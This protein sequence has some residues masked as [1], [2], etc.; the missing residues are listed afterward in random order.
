M[1]TTTRTAG[2][3]ALLLLAFCGPLHAQTDGSAVFRVTTL[4]TPQ[5][6]AP[7][8][9]IAIWVT[10][11]NGAFVRTLKKQAGS[12]KQVNLVKWVAS[13]Q[14]NVVDAITGATLKTQEVHQITWNCRNAARALVGDGTYRIMVEM[15]SDDA[16][17]PVTPTNYIQFTKGPAGVTVAPA[18]LPYFTGISLTYTP[19]NGH[20]IAVS[21]IT[22]ASGVT[23]TTIPITITVTNRQ[24]STESFNIALSNTTSSLLIGS[25]AVTALAP[26]S[27]TNVTI[28]WNTTALTSGVYTLKA[29]AAAVAGETSLA[30]N[31]LASTV[32][33]V[34]A[35]VIPDLAVTAITPAAGLTGAT[36]PVIVTVTNRKLTTESFS[37]V[38][39]N[40]TSGVLIGSA[41]VSALGPFA[42]TTVTINWNTTS[43]P[44]GGYTLKAVAGPAAGETN[45]ANNTLTSGL[46]LTAP[47]PVL[48]G[49][50]TFRVTTM[51]TYLGLD[52]INVVAI[53]VT[54]GNGKFIRTLKKCATVREPFLLKWIASS[55]YNVV[56]AVTGATLTTQATHQV[57][58]N[59]RNAAGK[60]VTN[61]V[62]QI[63]VEMTT[64]DAQGP[65]T[66]INYLAFTK[67]KKAVTL[68]PANLPF[69]TGMA[70]TYTPVYARDIAVTAVRPSLGIIG[71]TIPV[72]ATL[73][74]LLATPETFTV[75]L[76]DHNTG[77]LLTSVSGIT[78]G[79]KA[80]RTVTLPWRT[81]G[82][83]GGNHIIDVVAGPVPG[84]TNI[85][86]NTR[87]ATL[88][89]AP[90][91]EVPVAGTATFR[92]TTQKTLKG[93]DPQNIMAIW[94][95]D[96]NGFFVKTLKKRAAVRQQYLI[97]WLASSR[98]D[99]TDAVTG[100]TLATH[101]AH[102]VTWNCR[103]SDGFVVPN[104]LYR[105]MVEM[106]TEDGQG[107]VTPAKY[108]QFNKGKTAVT[109]A[110]ANLPNF[111]AMS[112]TY[113][114]TPAPVAAVAKAV[115]AAS[116]PIVATAVRTPAPSVVKESAPG[117]SA[118]VVITNGM[119][120][121]SQGATL[122]LLADD[123]TGTYLPLGS[124]ALPG[125]I[126][127]MAA[128]GTYVITANG[129]HGVYI[130][131]TLNPMDPVLVG[132]YPTK[133]AAL[134]VTIDGA[135]VYV[136]D[137][138]AG[139]LAVDVSDPTVPIL[140]G[141][142][143]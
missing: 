33:L 134:A 75:A 3:T 71:V 12:S 22:P 63:R 4:K 58:W 35:A 85:A 69:F 37:V 87:S 120:A 83:A 26:F 90:P 141:V 52:P 64:Q 38:L 91:A 54:D 73:T 115:P 80:G 74:N 15:T 119:L 118:V 113:T 106:T 104:G 142:V 24:S 132:S 130:V 29:T 16:V 93:F 123:G 102:V 23:G 112:L 50:L 20:D 44:A 31:T 100:A 117:Y 89:L 2:L 45:L 10:D 125:A 114:P 76:K 60:L 95:T 66:P 103:N 11:G 32:T 21:R 140:L 99:I 9:I 42:G 49:S 55:K 36:I 92:V 8:N 7:K 70:L 14:L 34:S 62:Y 5:N 138:A 17:G 25:A 96:S 1:K 39:S 116:S 6:Y 46:V 81:G 77:L 86:N 18:N 28:S 137:E 59:C 101:K 41:P 78:L 143:E 53:W 30:D 40:T 43:L 139:L 97:Q 13:S 47:I 108:I 79:P 129:D 88:Y 128:S 107:P 109:V 51:R 136:V 105:I 65:I 124:L 98:S 19:S 57:T 84:E 72:V 121:A 61:G 48:D 111:T 68:A 135:T 110:P 127:A 131:D 122:V 27:S 94:V 82:R 133:G 67:G 126:Q 56:D